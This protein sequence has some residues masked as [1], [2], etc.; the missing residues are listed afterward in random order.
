MLPGDLPESVT[1]LF[2]RLPDE[3]KGGSQRDKVVVSLDV[4]DDVFMFR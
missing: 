1:V 2:N 3:I 4:I